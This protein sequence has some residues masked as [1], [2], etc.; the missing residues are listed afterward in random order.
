MAGENMADLF[1]MKKS[2]SVSPYVFGFSTGSTVLAAVRV[3]FK[4]IRPTSLG[5]LY[6]GAGI[7]TFAYGS[8][9]ANKSCCSSTGADMPQR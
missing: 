1:S 4:S 5:V 6:L 2:W 9:G 8:L 7:V 3:L